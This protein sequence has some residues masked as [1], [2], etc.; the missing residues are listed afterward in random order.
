MPSN[1][2]FKKKARDAFNT[3]ADVSV[4]AYKLAEEKAKVLAKKAK[5]NA[6]IANERATIR[7]LHVEIGATYYKMF[8]DAPNEA[9]TQQCKDVTA[10]YERIACKQ[11]ELEDLR[12]YGSGG[13]AAHQCQCDDPECNADETAKDACHGE[14]GCCG[15]ADCCNEDKAD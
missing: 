7:R 10:A 1:D 6:G 12:N 9:L 2:D 14:P 15:D 13:E 11:K 4:E 5:L 3:L 8:K